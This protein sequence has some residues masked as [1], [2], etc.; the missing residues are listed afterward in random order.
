MEKMNYDFF[1]RTIQE[2]GKQYYKQNRVFSLDGRN[3]NYSALI[4]GTQPYHVELQVDDNGNIIKASC[5]CPY[6]K[7][8]NHC[9]HE[10]ALYYALEERLLQKMPFFD[11]VK[12][13][14]KYNRIT[15][16]DYMLHQ[17]FMK[18][19]KSYLV[20]I[21]KMNQKG[22]FDIRN[23]QKVID[24]L[25]SLSYPNVYKDRM[26]ENVFTA[27]KELMNSQETKG[28]IEWLYQ[29]FC[30]KDYLKYK[31]YLLDTL[32]IL[33]IKEQL[34][35]LK[36]VLLKKKNEELME[37]YIAL[38]IKHHVDIFSDL[39]D[40]T[41]YKE[42][43][44][45]NYGMIIG[46]IDHDRLEEAAYRY[47]E[48]SGKM[49]NMYYLSQIETL[50]DKEKEDSFY[51]Y[52]LKQCDWY[53]YIQVIHSYY[54]LK[55]FYGKK[56]KKYDERFIE[57]MHK[58]C[59]EEDYFYILAQTENIEYLIKELIVNPNFGLFVNFIEQ[60]R[61]FDEESYL[62]L[63]VECLLANVE[64]IKSSKDYQEFSF[65]FKRLLNNVD[66]QLVKYE[67]VRLFL[68]RYPKRKKLQ[69]ILDTCLDEDGEEY[70]YQY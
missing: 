50:I 20:S 11:A 32:S 52:V 67:I 6:A 70:E 46:L 57:Y 22:Q 53:D 26:I 48:I 59:D 4:L 56:W 38:A 5:D 10:A 54:D 60:I 19:L 33:D 8:G 2:R 30:K 68:E 29:C 31:D 9:K 28:T 63:Y 21:I 18:E 34:K 65:D 36:K 24:S 66:D 3:N 40:M 47:K 1:S 35:L 42:N 23:Y 37:D 58:N 17:K 16:S 41:S 39:K 62:F 27:Y 43:D 61:K 14:K 12:T 44:A 69:E 7:E 45:Y 51:K 13:L 15:H 64:N 49:K 25:V 55:E